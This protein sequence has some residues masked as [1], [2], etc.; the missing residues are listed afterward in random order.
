MSNSVLNSLITHMATELAHEG[1]GFGKTK[2]VK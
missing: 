1:I 2:L